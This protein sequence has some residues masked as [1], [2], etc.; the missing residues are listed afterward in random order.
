MESRKKER[1]NSIYRY[2]TVVY[3]VLSV[4][5]SIVLVEY[6]GDVRIDE[7]GVNVYLLILFV[8]STPHL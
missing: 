4:A 1:K 2:R 3:Y 7:T 6:I 5:G 8:Y